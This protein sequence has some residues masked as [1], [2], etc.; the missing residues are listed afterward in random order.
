[1]SYISLRLSYHWVILYNSAITSWH[2]TNRQVNKIWSIN[3]S[4]LRF[5]VDMQNNW[6]PLWFRYNSWSDYILMS[7]YHLNRLNCTYQML[8]GCSE[9]RQDSI[10]WRSYISTNYWDW[11]SIGII[12]IRARLTNT[13]GYFCIIWGNILCLWLIN[14]R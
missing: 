9:I 1:M 3:D 13:K 10:L 5:S 14:Y 7:W 2:G 12:S 4:A 6:R 8:L 11:L